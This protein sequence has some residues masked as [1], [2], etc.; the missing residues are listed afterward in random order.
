MNIDRW[1]RDTGERVVSTWL[2]YAALWL[3]AA[4]TLGATWVEAL[5]A[6][7]V[8]PVLVVIMSALPG[9]TYTGPVWWKDAA[10][11]VAR[12]TLQGALGVLTVTSTDL[13]SLSTW[14]AAGIAAG[15]AALTTVKV[16]LARRTTGTITPASLTT[17][18]TPSNTPGTE[19]PR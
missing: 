16:L 6:A 3:L 12:S 2:Q 4:P 5:V 14:Q 9:L 11:R 13:L 8:P 17:Y 18:T 7:T 10:C 1:L 15:G 19:N